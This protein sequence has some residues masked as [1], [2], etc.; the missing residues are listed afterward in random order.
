MLEQQ[1]PT[2]QSRVYLRELNPYITCYMCAGYLIDATSITECNHRFCKSCIVR[3]L[4]SNSC[5]PECDIPLNGTDPFS[6]LAFDRSIQDLVYKLVPEL[7]LREYNLRAEF[8]KS[9]NMEVPNFN[10]REKKPQAFI[11][12]GEMHSHSRDQKLFLEVRPHPSLE[13]FKDANLK[14]MPHKNVRCSM[15]TLVSHLKRFINCRVQV[16]HPYELEVL[17]NDTILE[18]DT[19]LKNVYLEMWAAQKKELPICI[20]YTVKRASH[21]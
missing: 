8:Y 1:D 10:L 17:C 9:R 21:S 2:H 20:Y 13:D 5:C 7:E 6:C 14:A 11:H 19:S 3:H 4:Q 15:R 18:K 16:P 12:P